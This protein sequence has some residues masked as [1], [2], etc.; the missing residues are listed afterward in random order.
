MG[1]CAFMAGRARFV[2][3]VGAGVVEVVVA[4]IDMICDHAVVVC[5]CPIA[6]ASAAR[7][8]MPLAAIAANCHLSIFAPCSGPSLVRPPTKCSTCRCTRPTLRGA[9]RALKIRWESRL[10]RAIRDGLR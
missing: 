3:G 9:Q 8:M 2:W 7:M 5:S 10:I 1:R 6:A 4:P